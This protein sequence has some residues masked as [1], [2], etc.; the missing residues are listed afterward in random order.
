MGAIREKELKWFLECLCEWWCHSQD[1]DL[2]GSMDFGRSVLCRHIGNEMP[3]R[4][5]SENRFPE[6]LDEAGSY[7]RRGSQ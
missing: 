2:K 5:S 1:K 6:F 3:V 4:S 7:R